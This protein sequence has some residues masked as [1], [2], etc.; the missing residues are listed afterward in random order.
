MHADARAGWNVAC[1]EMP[2]RERMH[3]DANAGWGVACVRPNMGA[4]D[5]CTEIKKLLFLIELMKLL[6]LLDDGRASI[7]L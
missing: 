7:Y 3:A 2:L 4:T 5:L 6:Y 1:V